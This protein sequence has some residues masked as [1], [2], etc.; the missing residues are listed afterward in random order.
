M[1]LVAVV[2]GGASGIGAACARALAVE[3]HRVVVADLAEGADMVCDVT[4]EGSV[5][6]LFE[7]VVAAHGRVDVV[8]NSAGTSTLSAVVD[9]DLGEWRRVVDVCLTGA[10]LVIK[11]AGRVLGQ[12][13]SIT[14]I[15]SLNARQPGGGLAAY[16][17]AKAGLAMLTEV[18]ALELAPRG[19]RVNAVSPG[20]VV[21]PLTAPALDI[22]G[23]E[24][25]YTANTPLGRS[26]RPE[27]IA[28]AVVFCSR[29]AWLTGEVMDLNG[30]AHLMRYP[31]LLGHVGRA[32]GQSRVE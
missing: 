22:P 12:G 5:A 30:G 2:V 10:F 32:F 29:A 17:S 24:D 3:D 26:G 11:H 1:D 15:T 7:G 14:S 23:I 18:A 13:G 16:C 28:E 31:D 19:I 6:A 8:V 27:E 21:T 9:H 4:S 25:D 20:L